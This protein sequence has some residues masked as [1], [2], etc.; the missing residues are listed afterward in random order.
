MNL[1]RY[2][3]TVDDRKK[4]LDGS[5]HSDKGGGGGGGHPDPKISGS[6]VSKKLFFGPSGL[7]LV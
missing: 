1:V 3:T 2:S 4:T 5:R 6:P 7:S